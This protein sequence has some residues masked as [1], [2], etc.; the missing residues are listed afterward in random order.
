MDISSISVRAR[1]M[2][3]EQHKQTLSTSMIKMNA[4]QQNQVAEILAQTTKTTISQ[5]DRNYNFSI[6]A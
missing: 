1:Q 4:E 6:Y 5:S 3:V 2:S